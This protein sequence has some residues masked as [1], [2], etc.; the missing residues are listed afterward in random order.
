MHTIAPIVASE[1]YALSADRHVLDGNLYV[2]VGASV[3]VLSTLALISLRDT[4]ATWRD[5][6]TPAETADAA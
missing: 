3:G 6:L 5:E 2:V 1:I 4:R